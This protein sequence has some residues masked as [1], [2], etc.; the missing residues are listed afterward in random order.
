MSFS[1]ASAHLVFLRLIS[2]TG[3]SYNTSRATMDTFSLQ[4]V[5]VHLSVF[6]AKE[7]RQRRKETTEQMVQRY[8][9]KKQRL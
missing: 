8:Q 9:Q 7:R 2:S 5:L 6:I 3:T 4:R 1:L